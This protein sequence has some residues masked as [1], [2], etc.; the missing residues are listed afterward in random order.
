MTVITSTTII[1]GTET[2]KSVVSRLPTDPLSTTS[3]LTTQT[4]TQTIVVSTPVSRTD[5]ESMTIQTPTPPASA[6]STLKTSTS[7]S[8]SE[9]VPVSTSTTTET[10]TATSEAPSVGPSTIVVTHVASKTTV[11]TASASASTS[12]GLVNAADKVARGSTLGAVVAF[13]ALFFGF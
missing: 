12:P 4:S 11:T 13:G 5:G 6:N 9:T 1:E 7:T 3:G 8:G 10:T 2:V